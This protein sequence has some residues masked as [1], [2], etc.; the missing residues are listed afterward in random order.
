VRASAPARAWVAACAILLVACGG[1]AIGASDSGTAGTA[2][3]PAGDWTTFDYNP[4][5]SGVGPADIGIDSEN[6]RRLRTRIVHIDG[7]VDSS[8]IEMHGIVIRGRARDV[9]VVTTTYGKTIAI[10]PGTGSRLWEFTPR[11]Y[12]SL[13][14]SPEITTA[15]PIADPGRRFVYA[16]DP[17]GLVHKLALAGGSE[18]HAGHWP[19]RATFL[20][21]REKLAS[22]FNISGGSLIV[23]TGGYDGDAPPYQGHVAVIDRGS[24]RITHVW[25]SLCSNRRHLI[26]PSTC[27]ANDSAIWGRNAPVLEPGSGRILFATGNGPFNGSTNWGDSVLE[28]RPDASRLLHNWT[29]TDQA[30]LNAS[31]TDLGSASP[32]ILPSVRGYRLAVQGGKAGILSLLNLNMLNGTRG[33]AGPRLGGE[34]QDISSPGGDQVFSAPAVWSHPGGPYVFVADGSGTAAYVLRVNGRPRLVTAWQNG[35]SGTSPILAGGLLYVYDQN[36]GALNVY[37]PASGR[38]VASLDASGGHWNSPIAIGGRVILPVG[39]AND[40]DTS[41]E[42]FIYHLPGR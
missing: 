16:A 41:G 26:Q 40:H 18:V 1:H 28:L 21:S 9:I 39:D 15:T 34:L 25:N 17:G 12:G 7:T 24:G 33:G 35:T 2:A 38:R 20:P 29:P 42:I 30:Q 4:Q 3:V 5:R 10:D 22:P 27:P 32:A 19:V 31:D 8:A 23:A 6:V 13:A 37:R 14:G 11:S 36:G